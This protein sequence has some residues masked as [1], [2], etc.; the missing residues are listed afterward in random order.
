MVTNEDR[1]KVDISISDLTY[2][3]I[4][5]LEFDGEADVNNFYCKYALFK[6]FGVRLSNIGKNCKREI[7]WHKFVLVSCEGYR[8]KKY[9][10]CLINN[11]INKRLST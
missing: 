2:E 8:Y 7:I 5:R 3:R 1:A 6:G 10:H 9:P 11:Y 4:L